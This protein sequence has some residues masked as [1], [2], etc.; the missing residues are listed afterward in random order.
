MSEY[1]YY[2]FQ[3]VDHPLTTRQMADL[4]RLSTRAHITPTSLTNTYNW[5]DFKGSP[6]RLMERYFDAHFY[7]ANWGS[8]SLMF[9]LPPGTLAPAVARRYAAGT[10]LEIR[11]HRRQTIVSFSTGGDAESFDPETDGTGCLASLLPLRRDLATGDV[12]CLYLGWLL[13]LQGG[14]VH[15][16]AAVPEPPPGVRALTGPLRAF[17]ELFGLDHDL[18]AV[19]AAQSAD[20]SAR[21]PARAVNAALAGLTTKQR[22]ALLRRLLRDPGP[23]ESQAFLESLLRSGRPTARAGR[24]R[25][26]VRRAGDLLDLAE[27]RAGRSL[28]EEETGGP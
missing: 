9:R 2:E 20:L 1:Q 3:A 14:H 5:G 7:L 18:L 4:R 27:R 25:P 8:R 17:V 19:A 15:E 23:A 22:D 10:G 16:T 11:T 6:G 26:V 21:L 13:G 28:R 24:A 12:R